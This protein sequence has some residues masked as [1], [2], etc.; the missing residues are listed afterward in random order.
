MTP[1][2]PEW[3]YAQDWI[4]EFRTQPLPGRLVYLPMYNL[5]Q[6][7]RKNYILLRRLF[8]WEDWSRYAVDQDQ[9]RAVGDD[10]RPPPT[11][12]GPLA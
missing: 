2:R 1:E 6:Y 4:G 5:Q 9:H 11:Y 3:G 7:E 10:H 12:P 8:V